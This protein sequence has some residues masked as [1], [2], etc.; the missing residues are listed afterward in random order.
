MKAPQKFSKIK[1]WHILLVVPITVTVIFLSWF[2]IIKISSE[3]EISRVLES[4]KTCDK[5]ELSF[6]YPDPNNKYAKQD[7]QIDDKTKINKLFILLKNRSYVLVSSEG[8]LTTT[9]FI[10][11]VAYKDR[12]KLCQFW[13]ILDL[14]EIGEESDFSRYECSDGDLTFNVRRELGLPGWD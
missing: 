7:I 13:I 10:K 11:V 1:I 14:L 2:Y 12:E 6:S 3:I 5:L 9:D 4:L 8:V